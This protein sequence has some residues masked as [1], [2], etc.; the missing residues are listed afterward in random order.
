MAGESHGLLI[1]GHEGLER[2]I[3]D[4]QEKMN[5]NE[6]KS[7][8]KLVGTEDLGQVKSVPMEGKAGRV[9][10]PQGTQVTEPKA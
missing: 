8:G 4:G 7:W 6:K 10:S 9:G 1:A 2:R 3:L 5:A